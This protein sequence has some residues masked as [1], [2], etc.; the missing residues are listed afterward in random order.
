MSDRIEAGTFCVAASLTKG[1]LEIKNFDYRI[2]KTELNLLKKL[3]LKLKLIKIK[4][5]LKDQK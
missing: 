1:S 4:F 3:V 5:L 2:I